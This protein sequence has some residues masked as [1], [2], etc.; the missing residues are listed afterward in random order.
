MTAENTMQ[1]NVGLSPNDTGDH[2]AVN[3]D[4]K[5]QKPSDDS[6]IVTAE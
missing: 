2:F 1:K 4:V 6:T 5:V 3:A